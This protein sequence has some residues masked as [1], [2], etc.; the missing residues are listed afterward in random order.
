MENKEPWLVVN[1]IIPFD[2]NVVLVYLAL[3]LEKFS[4]KELLR[5]GKT[6]F[7]VNKNTS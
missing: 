4:R 2:I 5:A 7:K 1:E 3:I 6:I